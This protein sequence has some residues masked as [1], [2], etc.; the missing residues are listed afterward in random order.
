MNRLRFMFALAIAATLSLGTAMAQD[1]SSQ[2]GESQDVG[3][4]LGHKIDHGGLV[5]NP[6]PQHVYTLRSL[7]LD[8]SKG[9]VLK[10]EAKKFAADIDFIKQSKKGAML[11]INYLKNGWNEGDDM[12]NKSGSYS[13]NIHH[14]EGITIT[15]FDEL[16]AFYALQTLRQVV[17]SE[18]AAQGTLPAL[19][20]RDWPDLK[21]R[22][23][24]EGFYGTPWSHATRS[25]SSTSMVA[26]R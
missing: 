24:V 8:I 11:T 4:M 2:R 17:E 25:H 22:G 6:T 18:V 21:Y 1:L 20:I 14:R 10:G 7:P 3:E 26:T 13:I 9:V 15:A 16:G 12:P 5:L 23:V 19:V